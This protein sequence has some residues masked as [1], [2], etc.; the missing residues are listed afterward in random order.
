M[1]RR[2]ILSA[3]FLLKTSEQNALLRPG[4]LISF[5]YWGGPRYRR[6]K[7]HIPWVQISPR[8]CGLKA[9]IAAMH[10]E[11]GLLDREME[12]LGNLLDDFA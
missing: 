8:D 1:L 7:T 6:K 3:L 12:L 4:H 2:E 5:L 9:K 10:V 11:F